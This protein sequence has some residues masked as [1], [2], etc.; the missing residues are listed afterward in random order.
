MNKSLLTLTIALLVSVTMQ[1]ANINR[2]QATQLARD[3][4]SKNFSNARTRQAAQTVSLHSVETGQSLV[5][6]FNVEGGGFVVVAGDDCAP[7]ILGYSER[8]TIDSSDIPEGMKALFAQYQAEMQLMIN[9]SQRAVAIGNLGSEISPLLEC[10]WGQGAPYNYMCPKYYKTDKKK[11]VKYK[12]Y[13]LTGCLATAVAQIM[14]YHKH[15]TE[16]TELPGSYYNWKK[17]VNVE[18]INVSKTLEW[19][20]MLPTYGNR[21]DPQGTQEQQNAIAKLMR[22]VGQCICMGYTPQASGAYDSGVLTGLVNY[23][24]Y[25]ASTIRHIQ[26]NHYSYEDWIK[27]IYQELVN[28]RPV[29][30]LAGSNTGGHAFVIDGYSHEDFFYINWGWYGNS[31]DAFRLALCNPSKKYEGGGTGDAGYSARQTAII[32]IQ[33]ATTPQHMDEALQGYNKLY[34]K[35]SYQRESA[36][37]DFDITNAIFQS[38]GNYSHFNKKYDYGVTVMDA[39]GQKVQSL[40]PLSSEYQDLEQGAG[41]ISYY[42][43]APLKIGASLADGTYTMQLLYRI[44]GDGEWRPFIPSYNVKFK[45][46]GNTLTFDCRPDWLTVKMDVEKVSGGDEP[47]Y[48]VKVTLK[49]ESTDQTFQRSIKLGR[50]NKNKSLE[51]YGFATVVAPGET[52]TYELD[53]RP[54]EYSPVKLYLYSYEDGVPLGEGVATGSEYKSDGAAFE[55]TCNLDE[56]LELQADQSYV[57]KAD[58]SYEISYTL[59]NTGT[60]DFYGY[61]ELIDSVGNGTS[62]VDYDE[63]NSTGEIISL[64]PGES[65]ELKLTIYDEGDESTLHEVSLVR[66]DDDDQPIE[67]YDTKPFYF[68]P[69]YDL[70][71]GNLSVTPTEPVDDELADY[72]VKGDQMTISGKISNPTGA[73]FAGSIV[74]RR[75]VTDFSKD[76]EIDEEGYYIV[77]PDKTYTQEVSI[78]AKGSIDYSELFDLKNL[79]KDKDYS[80]LVDFD[81]SF[82]SKSSTEDVPMFYSAAYLLNDGTPTSIS[83]ISMPRRQSEAIYDL[84]GRRINGQPT[85]GIYIK[86]NRKIMIK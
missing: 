53:Y 76:L 42:S 85:R 47:Q 17:K 14:Y 70:S 54:E 65:R 30:F 61:V 7:T 29:Y 20:K 52:K 69:V 4:M 6:A 25:D 45:I 49:N 36:D 73:D 67:I 1:A 64:K 82:I 66:Y 28:K 62:M 35:Y 51:N 74:V 19:D 56:A 86:D 12:A 38:V 75:Y 31:D 5:Y 24:N 11:R 59:K 71:F 41:R 78:P 26:R 3:F 68:Q 60:G 33:P 27:T 46:K 22:L 44:G 72:I 15:P 32:G 23:F 50:D 8:S 57:L 55:G 16:I 2:E 81:I 37:Q 21:N 40:L 18:A 10:K 77:E 9:G 43:S 13:S 84:Q 34:G 39:D 80:V 58:N 83:G 63:E 48:N 79:V